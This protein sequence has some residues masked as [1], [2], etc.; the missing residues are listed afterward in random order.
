MLTI[1]IYVWLALNQNWVDS[2]LYSHLY[3]SI[4]F[5]TDIAL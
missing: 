4:G 2:H 1:R 3:S 5:D